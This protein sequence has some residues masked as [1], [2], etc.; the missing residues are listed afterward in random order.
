MNVKAPNGVKLLLDE[1]VTS[2]KTILGNNLTG[3]YLHGS[4]AMGCFN[5][6]S[7]DI[8]FLVVTKGKVAVGKRKE[9]ANAMLALNEKAPTKGLEMSVI[10]KDTLKEMQHPMPFEFHFSSDWIDSFRNNGVNL[11]ENRKDSDLAAHLTII[12]TRGITLYGPPIGEL[13]PDVP[14]RYY[15]DSIEADAKD[16]LSDMPSNPVYNVLNLCRVW[17]YKSD[18]V[19]MSKHE[20]GEWA[21]PRASSKQAQII[22]K[23]LK[24]YEGESQGEW[25]SEEL[26]QFG[27]EFADILD[28]S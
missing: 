2:F 24:E 18:K 27:G 23:A 25:S 11:A 14:E 5:P 19:V 7:S 26:N 22:S 15:Y 20:G 6:V 12:K 13:F 1:I 17:A 10:T 28:I 3:I 16:I 21:L 4:L 9:I 8:D